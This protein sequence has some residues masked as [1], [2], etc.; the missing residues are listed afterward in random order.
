LS[1]NSELAAELLPGGSLWRDSDHSDCHL[2]LRRFSG[3]DSGSFAPTTPAAKPIEIT[4][5]ACVPDTKVAAFFSNP[6]ANLDAA[7]TAP[8][9]IDNALI[10]PV[11][12]SENGWLVAVC[13]FVS[14]R[15]TPSARAC[16]SG[17]R[18]RN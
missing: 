8:L 12:S 6:F 2:F 1:Y 7:Q 17:W 11:P 5:G 14:W 9:R 13:L 15:F 10:T 16:A 3:G 4:R 18:C